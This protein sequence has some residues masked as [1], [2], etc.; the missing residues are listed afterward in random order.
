MYV[1]NFD[2]LVLVLRV[3]MLEL[4]NIVLVEYLEGKGI[5]KV[6]DIQFRVDGL[7]VG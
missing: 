3:E 7:V 4:E 6:N 2:L 5:L 1:F